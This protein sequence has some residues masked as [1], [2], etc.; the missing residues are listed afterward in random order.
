MQKTLIFNYTEILSCSALKIGGDISYK[1]YME[2]SYG[3]LRKSKI[4]A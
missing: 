1:L 4:S 3:I 2:E